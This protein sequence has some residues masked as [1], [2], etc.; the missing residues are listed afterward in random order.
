MGGRCGSEHV[1]RSGVTTGKKEG[2]SAGGE[3]NPNDELS[4]ADAVCP[5]GYL[6]R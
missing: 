2:G 1:R 5:F 3:R 6:V 4:A